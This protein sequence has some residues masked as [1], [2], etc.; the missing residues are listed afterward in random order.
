MN[1]EP[2]MERIRRSAPMNLIFKAR[3]RMAGPNW[4]FANDATNKGSVFSQ[5]QNYI[6]RNVPPAV[7]FRC[8]ILRP[9]QSA[10][11][12]HPINKLSR[13]F[14]CAL[15]VSVPARLC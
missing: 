15:C 14:L 11:Q 5:S 7:T 2:I 12:Q 6:D 9:A 10:P 1:N 4:E 8:K 13:V 3:G